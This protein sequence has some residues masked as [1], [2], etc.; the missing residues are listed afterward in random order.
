M[1]KA[2]NDIL[3]QHGTAG[4]KN[5]QFLDSIKESLAEIK[6]KNDDSEFRGQPNIRHFDVGLKIDIRGLD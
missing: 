6:E 2:V 4:N 3:A 1:V 5:G